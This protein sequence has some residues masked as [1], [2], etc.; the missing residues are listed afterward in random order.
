MSTIRSQQFPQLPQEGSMA[1]HF[2][3]CPSS[4]SWHPSLAHLFLHRLGP[5]PYKPHLSAL[6][7]VVFRLGKIPVFTEKGLETP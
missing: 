5:G 6:K 1:I 2:R 3:L 7:S 4:P